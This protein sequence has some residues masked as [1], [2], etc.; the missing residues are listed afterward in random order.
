MNWQSLDIDVK[1]RTA[2]QIKT[3]CPKCS[4]TRKKKTDPCLSVNIDDGVYLC[5]NCNWGG[6]A[7]EYEPKKRE[8]VRPLNQNITELSDKT[9]KWFTDVR[10][11]SQATLIR[12]NV[13]EVKHYVPQ[14]QAERNCIA[15][16]YFRDDVVINIKYRDGQKNFSLEKDAELIFYGLD[17]IKEGT[18]AIICEGEID[19]L[20]FYEAGI[21]TSVS[22]PNGAS[23][24]AKLEYLDNCWQYFEGKE[25][26]YIATD[27]DEPGLALREELARRIGKE[28]CWIVTYPEGCKDANDV[29]VRDGKDALRLCL[30]EAKQYPLEGIMEAS[31]F[32][33][34]VW[35][36]YNNGFPKGDKVGFQYF[37]KLL[38]FRT[39]ELTT[40]TGTPNAGK[41]EFMDQLYVR[42]A[43]RYG[44]K[45]GIYSAENQPL[46]L[47]FAK[48][49]EKYIGEPF[50]HSTL[51]MSKDMV[52]LA[53]DFINDHFFFIQE[54]DAD[55]TIDGLLKKGRELVVRKGIK[56]FVVDPWNRLEHQV[57]R[58]QSETQ[59][60]SEVLTKIYRFKAVNN[61][62]FFLVAHPTKI[63]KDKLGKFEVPTMYDIAGS[64]HF[65]NKT[66]NG[67]CVY[68]DFETNHVHVY[69]QKVRFKF[70]GGIGHA[71]FE[72]DLPTG[73]YKEQTDIHFSK[74]YMKENEHG[75]PA[76]W[77][78]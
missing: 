38:S 24:G 51:K 44:W 11:I 72:Y 15:F 31:E 10:G 42:L 55:L 23:K 48:L 17:F 54:D 37:D 3:T 46:A 9:L 19:Q 65:Y 47:H 1:G 28:R 12:M 8:Y 67:L 29:L 26:I 56:G 69:V 41:S 76:Y 70:I 68:R 39:G 63:K 36:I 45:F 43:A 22:V 16:R 52:D 71:E 74:E 78:R 13:G 40:I 25:K 32:M 4:H 77:D 6:T 30:T 57:P 53:T 66:D 33:P 2:G 14:I 18:E 58:G 49:A 60:I 21:Y 7:K 20:S 73:R 5:H 59:Y 75:Y 27:S 64:A 61:V 62:H 34:E 35:N 50:F